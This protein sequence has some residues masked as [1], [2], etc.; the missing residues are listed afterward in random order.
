LSGSHSRTSGGIKN[1]C[2]RSHA[3]KLGPIP[4]WS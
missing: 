2:S 3:M 4:A 1:D